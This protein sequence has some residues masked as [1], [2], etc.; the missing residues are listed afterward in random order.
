M[1]TVNDLSLSLQEGSLSYIFRPAR[2]YLDID[3]ALD[4]YEIGQEAFIKGVLGQ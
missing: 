4:V 2:L 3:Y 1:S